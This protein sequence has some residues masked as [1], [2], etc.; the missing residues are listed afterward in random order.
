MDGIIIE[1]IKG[2][3][4]DYAI[5]T[6]EDG[7][8]F[9]DTDEEERNYMTSII[10]PITDQAELERKYV[11]IQGDAKELNTELEKQRIKEIDNREI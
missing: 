9:Y 8:C 11:A 2:K 3:F 1:N 7:Y 5:L 4:V 6:A 10:T